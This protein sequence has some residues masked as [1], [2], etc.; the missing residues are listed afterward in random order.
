MGAAQTALR[1]CEGKGV[2]MAGNGVAEEFNLPD[3]FPPV[4]APQCPSCPALV[5]FT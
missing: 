1:N 4:H 3:R 2:A 5:R